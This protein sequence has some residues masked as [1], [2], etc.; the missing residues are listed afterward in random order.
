MKDKISFYFTMLFVLVLSAFSSGCATTV[1]TRVVKE[2]R[3]EAIVLDTN[4]LRDCGFTEPPNKEEFLK[5]KAARQRNMLAVYSVDLHTNLI[6][7]NNRLREVRE[8]QDK[9]IK[10][11]EGR[12]AG[13]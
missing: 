11:V 2:V 1:E 13:K 3:Y 10:T 9:L 6:N 4:L 5:N 7:C 8:L 12:N